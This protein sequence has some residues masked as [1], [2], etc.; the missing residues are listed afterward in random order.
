MRLVPGGGC[1]GARLNRVA[2]A[3]TVGGRNIH[4]LSSLSLGDTR[5]AIA[6]LDLDERDRTIAEA[7]LKEIQARLQFL[8]DVGLDYMTLARGAA[9]PAGGGA[10][11]NQLP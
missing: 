10:Q 8:L 2:L 7:V 6:A 5:A 1:G 4:E 9:T 11:R 3:V